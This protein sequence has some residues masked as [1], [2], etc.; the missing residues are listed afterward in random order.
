MHKAGFTWDE[1]HNKIYTDDELQAFPLLVLN[2]EQV[3][4][5]G[6]GVKSGTQ[7]DVTP[8][9]PDCGTGAVQTSPLYLPPG[10]MPRRAKMARTNYCDFVVARDLAQALRKA[11]VSGLE[12]RQVRSTRDRRPLPWWQML[13][14]H[15][16]PRLSP[17][18]VGVIHDMRP[19][20]GC[21]V[22]RRDCFE[23]GEEFAYDRARVDPAALPDVVH[24]WEHFGRSILHDDPERG[25]GRGFAPPLMMIKPKVFDIFQE[26]G[27]KGAGFIPVRIE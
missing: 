16:M 5:D 22:C 26:L 8:G 15:T 18:S 9:C 7:Y 20:W 4:I 11:K 1:L 3:V 21:P 14:S 25:L 24:T 17:K 23:G 13:S 2:Q 12:L 27:A 6:G 19:G 10:K